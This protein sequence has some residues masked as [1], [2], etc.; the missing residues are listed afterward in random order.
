MS[1]WV[2]EEV[3]DVD[4][5][6]IRSASKKVWDIKHSAQQHCTMWVLKCFHQ[7]WYD[8]VCD[9]IAQGLFIEWWH[10]DYSS[11]FTA[12]DEWVVDAVFVVDVV[13]SAANESNDMK[14]EHHFSTHMTDRPEWEEVNVKENAEC[15]KEWE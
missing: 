11:I 6:H 12:E 2:S 1:D 13:I 15:V 7:E 3:I 4:A 9:E 8:D 10:Q 5:Y 14:E